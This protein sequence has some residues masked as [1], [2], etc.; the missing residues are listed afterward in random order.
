MHGCPATCDV[1]HPQ[2]ISSLHCSLVEGCVWHHNSRKP[3]QEHCFIFH[4]SISSICFL[5]FD[6]L[7]SLT[8]TFAVMLI[9]NSNNMCVCGSYKA[10][11]PT[12]T[13]LSL[14]LLCGK[15]TGQHKL[16]SVWL[17]THGVVAS[18]V[19]KRCYA[20]DYEYDLIEGATTT[21]Q[22]LLHFYFQGEWLR[23]CWSRK[24]WYAVHWG[25]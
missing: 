17:I 23:W 1:T 25:H 14:L 10:L 11:I 22:L 16:P 13:F 20:L 9:V 7:Q 24:G 21:R 4:F 18:K 2:H 15:G 19:H 5:P 12:C 8:H 6:N 3:N